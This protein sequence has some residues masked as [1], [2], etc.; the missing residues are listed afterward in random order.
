MLMYKD[1]VLCHSDKVIDK[2]APRI[3]VEDLVWD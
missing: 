3:I 2:G 1:T